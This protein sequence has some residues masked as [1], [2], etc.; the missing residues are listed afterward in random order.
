MER[1]PWGMS[2]PG[3]NR[4]TSTSRTL[5]VVLAIAVIGLLA[6]AASAGWAENG[7]AIF[8]TMAE[9]GLAWCL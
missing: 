1:L 9:G 4:S 7:V 3:N 8:L 6:G 5:A 2:L